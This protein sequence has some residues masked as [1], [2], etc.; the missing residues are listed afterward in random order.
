MK[1]EAP[2]F[3]EYVKSL[4]MGK[5]SNGQALT[6]KAKKSKLNYRTERQPFLAA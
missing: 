4:R 2:H 3:G 1:N 6:L 5:F